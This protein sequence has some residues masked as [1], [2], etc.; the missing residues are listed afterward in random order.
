MSNKY[1]LLL[2]GIYIVQGTY[3]KIDFTLH[4]YTTYQKENLKSATNQNS[5][6][7]NR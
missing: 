5:R 1:P 3:H 7:L 2:F 6:Y 4:I